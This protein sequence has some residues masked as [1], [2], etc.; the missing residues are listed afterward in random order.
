MSKYVPTGKPMGRPEKPLDWHQFEELCELQCTQTE[1]AS[2]FRI[3]ANTLHDK[4]V[5]NYGCSY[6]EAY[7]KLSENGKCSLRRNQFVLSKTNAGMAIWLGK[8][9]LG[10][11]DT[12]LDAVF[13]EEVVRTFECLMKQLTTIQVAQQKEDLRKSIGDKL[14]ATAQPDLKIITKSESTAPKS[15]FVTGADPA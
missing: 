9:W 4:V 6:S 7:K 5:E 14:K 1:I 2:F 13:P 3:H 15:V 10:Q 12:I 11:K 8:Q